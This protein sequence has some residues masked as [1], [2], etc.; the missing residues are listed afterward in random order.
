[1]AVGQLAR[2]RFP[3][4]R[5]EEGVHAAALRADDDHQRVG[6][7]GKLG[8]GIAG[9]SAGVVIRP[10][11]IHPVEQAASGG[12]DIGEPLIEL[13][14]PIAGVRI[15]GEI[16]GVGHMHHVQMGAEAVR[17]VDGAPQRRRTRRLQ[18]LTQDQLRRVRRVLPG[19]DVAGHCASFVGHSAHT[20][21]RPARHASTEASSEPNAFIRARKRACCW[22]SRTVSKLAVLNVV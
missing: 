21:P 6:G 18:V 17:K 9:P 1:M 19:G 13:F 8:K 22:T 4:E 3:G 5:F 2:H 12:L 7:F 15:D 14:L 20:R 16:F 11:R 10:G